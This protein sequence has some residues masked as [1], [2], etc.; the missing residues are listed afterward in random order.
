[1]HMLQLNLILALNNLVWILWLQSE[2]GKKIIR[3]YN[4]M[5][6]VLMEFEVLYH[7]GWYRA[8]ETARSGLNA[9]LLVQHPETRKLYVNFDP[10]IYELIQEAKYLHKL[11]LDIPEAA[12]IM[13]RQEDQLKDYYVK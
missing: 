4:K 7:R 9:A 2:E 3:N 8:V 12:H 11:N 6:A 10:Q 5:A 13:C 1:M